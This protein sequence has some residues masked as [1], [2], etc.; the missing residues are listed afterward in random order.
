VVTAVDA[1]KRLRAMPGTFNHKMLCSLAAP[2]FKE[3]DKDQLGILKLQDLL[4]VAASALP[5]YKPGG[6]KA[7]SEDDVRTMKELEDAI[8]LNNEPMVCHEHTTDFYMS[9]L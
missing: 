5:A 3:L 1:V 2:K 8:L 4:I 9:V 6:M 7:S